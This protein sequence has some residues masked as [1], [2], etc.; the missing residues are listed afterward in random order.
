ML[1]RTLEAKVVRAEVIRVFTAWRRGSLA[2][3][4]QAP[5]SMKE[6]LLL[7][8]AQCERIDQLQ[9]ETEAPQP[10]VKMNRLPP[11]SPVP[12]PRVPVETNSKGPLRPSAQVNVP[13]PS[14]RVT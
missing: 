14:R 2:P 5:T 6:A 4:V 3:M 13:L 8:R 10:N 9:I 12:V 7:A 11:K 1:A